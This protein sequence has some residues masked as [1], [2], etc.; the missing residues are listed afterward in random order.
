MGFGDVSAARTTLKLWGYTKFVIEITFQTTL[1][2]ISHKMANKICAP[3]IEI[4]IRN[5]YC[6]NGNGCVRICAKLG[7]LLLLYSLKCVLGWR[8]GIICKC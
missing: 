5:I 6:S 7:M 4:Y 8:L 3:D 2:A 1:G